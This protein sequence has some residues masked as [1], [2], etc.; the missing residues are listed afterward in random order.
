DPP[1]AVDRARIMGLVRD[2]GCL[3]LDPINVVARS[4]LLVLWSRLGRFDPADLDA[5]LWE[6]RRLFEYWAHRASIVLTEDYPIHHLLMR[7]YP[8]DL[9]AHSRGMKEWVQ[10]NQPLRRHIMTR[11]RK[12]GPLRSRDLEDRSHVSWTSSG[13]TAERNVERMLVYLWTKG[14]IVVAGRGGGGKLWDLAERWFPSWTPK[15]RL[16]ETRIS[17]LAADRSLGVL[18]VARAADIDR[19]FTAERYPGLPAILS[20]LQR[21]KLVEPVRIAA[22]RDA[23]EW[24]GV[25]YVHTDDLPLIDRLAAGEWE[26][27]TTLLSPFDNLI[28]DRARTELLFGFSFRMEIY[29]PKALRRYG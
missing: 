15:D 3:Q 25:W 21:E 16:P 14:R 9:Y 13:W 22:S 18:G 20:R 7:R 5:L 17:R 10:Q 26:P 1:V 4:H 23:S 28:I 2:L 24:P 8:T 11:I 19:N 27:R 12:E 29:V 6:E